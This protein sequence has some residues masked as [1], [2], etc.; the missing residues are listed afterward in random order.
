M[1]EGVEYGVLQS[2]EIESMVHLIASAF[3]S[4]EPPAVAMGLTVLDLAKFLRILVPQA[5]TGELTTVAR[6]R[7][8]GEVV[9][10]MLCDD[11]AAPLAVDLNAVHRG[12]RPIFGVLGQLDRQYSSGKPAQE[13]EYVHLLMLAVDARFVGRGIA[14]GLVR[15]TLE[16]A[17]AKGYRWAVTEATGVVSQHLFRKLGFQ[18]RLR[19]SYQD[20]KYEGDAVFSSITAHGGVALMD[21]AIL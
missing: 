19:I 4:A 14:Q 18:E 20:Y 1:S 17:R 15:S 16:N 21:T 3:S 13:G 7:A 11:F 5:L 6:L 2:A 9:G 12:F 8:S 10:A